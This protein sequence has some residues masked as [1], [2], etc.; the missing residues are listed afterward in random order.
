MVAEQL[1]I[2]QCFNKA[3]SPPRRIAAM[4][5][6]DGIPMPIDTVMNERL[7]IVFQGIATSIAAGIAEAKSEMTRLFTEEELRW[8][9][10]LAGQTEGRASGEVPSG[11]FER[12]LAGTRRRQTTRSV[13]RT[14]NCA[15]CKRP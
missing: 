9:A 14:Q 6:T 1:Q 4:A 3:H 2:R 13:H 15:S 7:E 8:Q 10:L 5:A 11:T 12:S